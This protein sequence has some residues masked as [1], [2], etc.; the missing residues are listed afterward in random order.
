M[1]GDSTELLEAAK[2][3]ILFF[4][5]QSDRLSELAPPVEDDAIVGSHGNENHERLTEMASPVRLDE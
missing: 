1:F 3:Y 2:T 5:R 4:V